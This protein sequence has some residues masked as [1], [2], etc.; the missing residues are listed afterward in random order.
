MGGSKTTYHERELS[1]EER[2]LYAQQ[3]QYMQ[4]IQPGID[5]LIN[6]GMSNLNKTFDPDWN[7]EYGTYKDNIQDI[8]NRQNTLLEG[9]LPQQWQDAKQNYYN[10]LYENTMGSGLQ[11]LAKNGVIS[12]SRMNTATNDWQKNLSSQ[13]SKDYTSDVNLYNNLLNTRESWL[14]QGFNALG[15]A[16]SQSRQQAT[17]YFNAAT[18]TQ[19]SNTDALTAIGN[20]NNNRG[21]VTS[22]GGSFFGN[23]LGGVANAGAGY[24]GAKLGR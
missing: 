16:A 15:Q 4:S 21:Y 1:P 23:L 10:R 14:N 8:L 6:K 22:S 13:M 19:K 9:N 2:Q 20:N 12:S 18:G 24:F 5:A 3:V 7:Q 17:D 11:S